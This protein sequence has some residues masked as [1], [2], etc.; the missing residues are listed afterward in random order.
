M[1]NSHGQNNTSRK[2]ITENETQKLVQDCR[3]YKQLSVEQKTELQIKANNI[4]KKSVKCV[5]RRK[6]QVDKKKNSG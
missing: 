5:M 6:S 1:I 2:N 4:M 3:E